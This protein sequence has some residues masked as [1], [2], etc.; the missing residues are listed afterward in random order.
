MSI[1]EIRDNLNSDISER[2]FV[3]IQDSLESDLK[4]PQIPGERITW[5]VEVLDPITDIIY[6]KF[7]LKSISTKNEWRPITSWRKSNEWTWVPTRAD[8]GV[9]Q[10]KAEISYESK[11]KV[12][13]SSIKEFN[14]IEQISNLIQ[15]KPL[16]FTSLDSPS[17]P[18]YILSEIKLKERQRIESNNNH[19]NNKSY[20]SR[21][22][23]KTSYRP[24][25]PSLRLHS[26]KP[27]HFSPQEEGTLIIWSVKASNLDGGELFYKFLLKSPDKNFWEEMTGWIQESTWAWIPNLSNIG[28]NQIKARIN[29]SCDADQDSHA[30]EVIAGYNILPKVHISLDLCSRE[31]E[32]G[33]ENQCQSQNKALEIIATNA[34][35]YFKND[36]LSA[37]QIFTPLPDTKQLDTIEISADGKQFIEMYEKKAKENG[38]F[39]HQIDFIKACM[40]Q[41]STKNFIMTTNTGSGKSLCFWFWVFHHLTK[42]ELST[43][44]LCF[45]IQALVFG[46][47]YRLGKISDPNSLVSY[48]K[49]SPPYAGTIKIN[50]K[51][52]SWTIWLGT[53][54]DRS[55]KKH[56]KSE[57]FRNARI[58]IS[59]TDKAHWSLMSE[60]SRDFLGNL[61]CLVLD[62]SHLYSGVFGANV[63]HFLKRLY[64]KKEIIGKPKPGIFLASATLPSAK[65]FAKK[66]LFLTSIDEIQHFQD[67]VKTQIKRIPIQEF[68]GCLKNPLT[69]GLLRYVL[70]INGQGRKSLIPFVIDDNLMG[71]DVNAIFFTQNKSFSRKI[72]RQTSECTRNVQIYDANLTSAK[73]RQREKEISSDKSKGLTLLATNALE[74]GIDIP[75]LD[76]CIMEDIPLNRAAMMQRIGRVGR[77]DGKPGLIIMRITSSPNDESILADPEA[78]FQISKCHPIPIPNHLEIIKWKHEIA[79]CDEL[80]T[81]EL[82][83]GLDIFLFEKIFNKYFDDI[84]ISK[85]ELVNRLENRYGALI[86]TKENYWE[87]NNFRPE[88]GEGLISVKK[89]SKE[90]G[91]INTIDIFRDAHPEAIYI[92]EEGK[93]YRV[94]DYHINTKNEKKKYWLETS[95]CDENL[96]S[97]SE[98]QVVEDQ[99]YSITRGSWDNV[100]S[101]EIST[102]YPDQANYPKIGSIKFG[103]WKNTRT[104]RGYNK[105]ERIE[106]QNIKR[107]TDDLNQTS[108]NEPRF[109]E[110][111]HFVSRDRI[112]SKNILN[113]FPQCYSYRTMGWEW[114]FKQKDHLEFYSSDLD[115]LTKNILRHFIANSI[116]SEI[117]GIDV[118]LDSWEGKFRVMDASLGGYGLSESLLLDGRIIKA[119]HDCS[120][121]LIKY[122]ELKERK[123]KLYI[124]HLIQEKPTFSAVDILV[125]VQKLLEM[126]GDLDAKSLNAIGESY[127]KR[128]SYEK[129]IEFFDNAIAA[130]PK[131]VKAQLNKG[132]SLKILGYIR[133]AID[134]YDLAINVNS[135][136]ETG[137]NEKGKALY[138]IKE[139][140]Q[141]AECFEKAIELKE[142]NAPAWHN[143]GIVQLARANFDQAI[144]C[145]DMAINIRPN[146]AE[147]WDCKGRAL[148]ALNRKADAN[149][150]FLQSRKFGSHSSK[151]C[152]E[153]LNYFEAVS[154][155]IKSIMDQKSIPIND[156][157]WINDLKNQEK[158]SEI[159]YKNEYIDYSNYYS[160]LFYM[161]KFVPCHADILRYIFENNRS[162]LNQHLMKTHSDNDHIKV[163]IL[164][165]GPGTELLGLAK[166][167]ERK[168]RK[169]I[170]LK[171]FLADQNQDWEIY[172]Q[173]L[174]KHIELKCDLKLNFLEINFNKIDIENT[175]ENGNGLGPIKE[176]DIFIMSYVFSEICK[177]QIKL[178]SFQ[179]LF[180]TIAFNAKKGSK[181]ILIDRNEP[182][183]KNELVEVLRRARI[184]VTELN[185]P[186]QN[187]KRTFTRHDAEKVN[188]KM[189][190]DIGQIDQ[191][192]DFWKQ[193][194][195]NGIE[196]RLDGDVFYLIGTVGQYDHFS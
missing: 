21:D 11:N 195:N 194:I 98:I 116:E 144:K 86:N 131:N 69:N 146:Y 184:S 87:Y 56:E 30:R 193:I 135:S 52:I 151:P 137:W 40:T 126:W 66:L 62:E 23:K 39:I 159:Y 141:S 31:T 113:K 102:D 15:E 77:R 72:K 149:S 18:R 17:Q 118:K 122:S 38:L 172:C 109:R 41:E 145:F 163:S 191:V 150:A 115:N 84:P 42:N 180:N 173:M 156:Q 143:F 61:E 48:D 134:C 24:P 19:F 73:R 10:I 176:I 125:I 1:A 153:K 187:L 168:A 68:I 123:F 82:E 53:T 130:D 129:A 43:A 127:L 104:W 114:D 37:F 99:S 25:N 112:A 160:Q 27:D 158:F 166:W 165:C 155:I 119:F 35:D 47:A 120:E 183:V 196:P 154:S 188:F 81:S 14:I 36:I 26:L 152:I 46:Q 107:N 161:C 110:I 192:N 139:Y 92:D 124:K 174:T 106:I 157:N 59:T 49:E 169:R 6:Y 7:W 133:E 4:E 28:N 189:E 67:S 117:N 3:S 33:D 171:V 164:G 88:I 75:G 54:K 5:K 148:Q 147:A 44:L 80:L 96:S 29:D 95:E 94:S 170:N 111:T 182:I 76:L 128:E 58:R 178:N 78:A 90:I 89:G 101:Y 55:M 70:F 85:E 91:V 100:I 185:Y 105:T 34:L 12:E 2:K 20:E 50:G 142:R 71:K 103:I 45:P 181:I 136:L 83:R 65:E 63:H 93:K 9:C 138:E 64:A 79:A 121:K 8:I 186:S 162:S 51:S 177:D 175:I 167:I 16:M 190:I 22:S 108:R 13:G 57:A 132:K 97:I 179:K 32:I 60:S 140:I 74:L